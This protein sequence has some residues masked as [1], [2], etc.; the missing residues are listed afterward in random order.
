MCE[1]IALK[2]SKTVYGQKTVCSF[3]CGTAE[4]NKINVATEKIN[5]PNFICH[6]KTF[7]P[8]SVV[9][10]VM[11]LFALPTKAV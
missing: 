3:R 4:F 7:K 9:S 11:K 10:P 6:F 2:I 1:I 5:P 8:K